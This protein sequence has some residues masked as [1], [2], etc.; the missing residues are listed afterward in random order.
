MN[1]LLKNAVK[2]NMPTL[3]EKLLKTGA[4]P[5]QIIGEYRDTLLT[6]SINYPN[7]NKIAK[8]LLKAGAD[9]NNPN[10]PNNPISA[11][12]LIG[13][14]EILDELIKK[15]AT[16]PP[17]IL[18]HVRRV[19][20]NINVIKK[21]IAHG[22]DINYVKNN[23]TV[24]VHAIRNGYYEEA[25]MLLELG[26]NPNICSPIFIA[27]LHCRDII[28][29]LLKSGAN[30]NVQN[31]DG[32]TP[33]MFLIYITRVYINNKILSYEQLLKYIKLFLKYEADITIRDIQGRDIFYYVEHYVS[34]SNHKEK[35]NKL[36]LEYKTLNIQL[37]AQ[38]YK[39]NKI[40]L[41][42]D[43]IRETKKMLYYG[44]SKSKSKLKKRSKSKT[45]SK[46]K[47]R[48]KSKLYSL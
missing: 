13:N 28:E 37:L 6:Y 5:N 24:L 2:Y 36:I 20:Y 32:L 45:K 4:N 26:A 16:I 33:L 40:P 17:Y 43:L 34:N 38:M 31:V 39:K 8:L 9:P 48:S 7:R 23:K 14:Y 10:N 18:F 29:L 11:C 30:I 3:V 42:I 46:S 44:K 22:V 47:K 12:V 41:N 25:K 19:D 35:I 27:I 15:G 21:F 1:K